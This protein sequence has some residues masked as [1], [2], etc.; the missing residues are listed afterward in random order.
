MDPV[1][2]EEND[3]WN[4]MCPLPPP[5]MKSKLRTIV[6]FSMCGSRAEFACTIFLEMN[7]DSIG[8]LNLSLMAEHT[9][10][11]NRPR[12]ATRLSAAYAVGNMAVLASTTTTTTEKGGQKK[13]WKINCGLLSRKRL[14]HEKTFY[15]VCFLFDFFIFMFIHYYE[16]IECVFFYLFFFF[17]VF[18]FLVLSFSPFS[19]FSF[20]LVCEFGG[21]RAQRA[22]HTFCLHSVPR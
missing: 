5:C 22:F 2:A 13:Q 10:R 17:F 15:S 6:R 14:L 3:V 19:L 21:K 11:V 20:F 1:H 8:V 18:L 7:R 12:V 4:N 9:V 16:V